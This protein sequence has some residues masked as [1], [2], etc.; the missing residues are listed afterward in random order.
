MFDELSLQDFRSMIRN[1]CIISQNS[2][3]YMSFDLNRGVGIL[4]NKDQFTWPKV[5]DMEKICNEEVISMFC[6]VRNLQ[7]VEYDF[8]IDD[9]DFVG[10]ELEFYI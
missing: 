8:S 4:L 10:Y 3:G 1:L 2:E 9:G 6:E 5:S 7:L